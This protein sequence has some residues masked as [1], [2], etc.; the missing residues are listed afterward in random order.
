MES[1]GVEWDGMA[2][3]GQSIDIGIL[4]FRF[5]KDEWLFVTHASAS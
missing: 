4:F 3:H 1:N 5:K 2:W